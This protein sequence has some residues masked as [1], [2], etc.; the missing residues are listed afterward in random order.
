MSEVDILPEVSRWRARAVRYYAGFWK[1]LSQIVPKFQLADFVAGPDEPAN[2]FLQTVIRLPVTLL[3]RP[4]PVGVVSKNYAL[5]QH[6]RVAELCLSSLAKAGIE[7][8]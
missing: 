7:I 4:T 2:P 3:E 6:R 1:D 8:S 5:V